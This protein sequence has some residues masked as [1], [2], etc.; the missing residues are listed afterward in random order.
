MKIFTIG[1][2]VTGGLHSSFCFVNE[3][4]RL[5]WATTFLPKLEK[6]FGKLEVR[7][8]TLPG[9]KI[10]DHC[11]VV[12]DGDC[13]YVIK[14]L[15]KHKDPYRYSFVLDSGCSEEVHKCTRPNVRT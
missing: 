8:S 9:L 2:T 3:T 14:A 7:Y 1:A 11:W 12:G 6:Q 15:R 4:E 5:L 13:E 10:G